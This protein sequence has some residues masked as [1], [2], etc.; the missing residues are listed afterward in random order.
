ML[1]S[2]SEVDKDELSYWLSKFVLEVRRKDG[3]EYNPRSLLSLIFGVCAAASENKR[4]PINVLGDPD[5]ASFRKLLDSEMK[6]LSGKGVG[7]TVRQAQA[8][9]QKQEDMLWKRKFL[10]DFNPTVLLR[11]IL[12]LNGRNFA[13]RS[14]QEHRDRQLRFK[15]RQITLHEP[16]GER[17]FLRYV[18]DVS[19]NR[20]GG[21]KHLKVAPKVVHQHENVTCPERC[22]VRIFKKYMK[23]CP[24]DRRDDSFY[25][26]PLQ[27][28]TEKMWYSRQPVGV[29]QLGKHTADMCKEAG[30]EGFFTNHSWRATAA[31]RMYQSGVDEQLIMERTGHTSVAGKNLISNQKFFINQSSVDLVFKKKFVPDFKCKINVK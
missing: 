25:L 30:L 20:Q 23:V 11:T 28:P 18:E 7:S 12:A 27:R 14:S 29:N 26:T 17:A 8:F 16:P 4:S 6:R 24:T 3:K 10:G 15:P 22:H 13:L 5:F 2:I 9:S 21:L 31:T 19:K 1:K